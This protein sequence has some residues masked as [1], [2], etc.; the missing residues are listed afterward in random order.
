MPYKLQTRNVTQHYLALFAISFMPAF[1]ATAAW[2]VPVSQVD[3]ADG[4][5]GQIRLNVHSEETLGY[6]VESSSENRIV[7]RLKQA[8]PAAGTIKTRFKNTQRLTGA[9]IERDHQDLKISLTGRN[10]SGVQVGYSLPPQP[11]RSLQLASSQTSIGAAAGN[12]QQTEAPLTTAGMPMAGQTTLNSNTIAPQAAFKKPEPA[13]EPSIPLSALLKSSENPAQPQAATPKTA[14]EGLTPEKPTLAT[15]PEAQTQFQLNP[16]AGQPDVKQLGSIGEILPG[17]N[18]AYSIAQ[19]RPE[20]MQTLTLALGCLLGL[21]CVIGLITLKLI[22]SRKKA[23]QAGASSFDETLTVESSRSSAAKPGDLRSDLLSTRQ[24]PLSNSSGNRALAAKASASAG[25]T[26]L[27]QAL[28][29]YGSQQQVRPQPQSKGHSLGLGKA[30][31]PQINTLN[32]LASAN[33]TPG[34]S[35][36]NAGSKANRYQTPVAP[37]K[38]RAQRPASTTLAAPTQ[39]LTTDVRAFLQTVAQRMESQGNS[40]M[41]SKIQAQLTQQA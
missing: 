39:P 15:T 11:T 35:V 6:S 36:P 5:R 1:L 30:S 16:D 25:N 14:P 19:K 9:I 2:A 18:K 23:A 17:L 12:N 22:I 24:S 40:A 8:N 21:G 41:A 3:F 26:T 37:Q 29:S 10:L 4:E 32:G 7:I 13:S 20:L 34:L 27:R 38:P 33:R 28:A 31:N